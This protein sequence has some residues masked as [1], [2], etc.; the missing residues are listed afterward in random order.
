MLDKVK[1]GL[2]VVSGSLVSWVACRVYTEDKLVALQ[3]RLAQ[4]ESDHLERVK[5]LETDVQ[6]RLD[7]LQVRMNS[8]E[9]VMEKQLFKALNIR[10]AEE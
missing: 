9:Q 5:A 6:A 2:L 3:D 8:V 7:V 1:S 4:M 10:I